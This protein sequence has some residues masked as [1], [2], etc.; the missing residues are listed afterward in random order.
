MRSR[1]GH[2]QS[3]ETG[4]SQLRIQAEGMQEALA[5]V[6]PIIF[7]ECYCI[8]KDKSFVERVK[9]TNEVSESK[10]E[11]LY[12]EDSTVSTIDNGFI[13]VHLFVMVH[14]FQGN[15]NDMRL[16]KNQ[17][18]LQHPDAVILLS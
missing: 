1:G 7:E 11:E 2:Y 18:S 15:H 13:G 9:N 17:I 10:I 4:S 12:N 6:S 3:L 5:Q 14:G 8:N 16:F